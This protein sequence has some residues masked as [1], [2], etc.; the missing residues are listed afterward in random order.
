L[1][2]VDEERKDIAPGFCHCGCGLPTK[3]SPYTHK[4][5]GWVQGQPRRFITGH[6]SRLRQKKNEDDG[7]YLR[8]HAP[9][10]P[11]A[12]GGRV[13][14][15]IL[16]AE[17]ALGK[18]LPEGA[19]IHHINGKKKDNRNENLVICQDR[20]Y[21]FLLHQRT[22]ALAACGHANWQRCYYC[23]A[24]DDPKNMIVHV[25]KKASPAF[26]HRAC[27]NAYRRKRW[28]GL[29]LKKEGKARHGTSG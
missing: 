22:R 24:Y 6:N 27:T 15:Q 2:R 11:R 23:K 7:R 16:V 3:V 28:A 19:E 8:K 13:F 26:E 5:Y 10:H 21:H 18:R 20:A 1:D 4:T 29:K 17:Q 14:E 9:A 25:K 12:N